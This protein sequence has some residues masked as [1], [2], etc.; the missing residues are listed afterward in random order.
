[1]RLV[2][3]YLQDML[4]YLVMLLPVCIIARF[5]WLGSKRRKPLLSQ[6]LSFATCA[7][8]GIALVSQTLLPR[9]FYGID[10]FRMYF[11]G[12]TSGYRSY[13]AVPLRTL[14][15]YLFTSNDMVSD[16]GAVALL[17]VSANVALFIP[18][19]MLAP[20]VSE[21]VR[22]LRDALAFGLVVSLAI[23]VAQFWIGRSAD[24]DDVILNVASVGLGYGCWVLATRLGRA[25]RSPGAVVSGGEEPA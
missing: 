17:N 22:R 14:W 4:R 18:L 25:A 23:E 13:N 7:A 12:I 2:D 9:A 24:I 6:E 19:G 21:R 3:I 16:W 10:D 8:Y 11:Q 5:L 1:M 20:W 15:A